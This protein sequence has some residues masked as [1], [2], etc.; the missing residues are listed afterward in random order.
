M[1]KTQFQ[2]KLDG[3]QI[4]YPQ[5]SYKSLTVQEDDIDIKSYIQNNVVTPPDYDSPS[6]EDGV[7]LPLFSDMD[8]LQYFKDLKQSVKDFSDAATSDTNLD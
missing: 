4:S 5:S 7:A 6:C 8:N 3:Y 2:H 1:F